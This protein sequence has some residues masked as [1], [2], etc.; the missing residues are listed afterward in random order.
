[1]PTIETGR[2][3]ALIGGAWVA[4]LAVLAIMQWFG[5]GV[6][7]DIWPFG[8][9][10]NTITALHQPDAGSAASLAWQMNDRNPLSPWSIVLV[11]NIILGLDSGFLLLRYAAGL[12][13]ALT[14]YGLVVALSG[15]RAFALVLGI[16]VAVFMANGYPE[17]FYWDYEVALIFALASVA[18]YAEFLNGGRQ[19]YRLYTF[20]VLAGFVGYGIYTI[21]CG[22][23]LAIAYLA[24]TRPTGKWRASSAIRAAV[25]DT[26]PYALLFALFLLIWRAVAHTPEAYQPHPDVGKLIKSLQYGPLHYDLREWVSLLS[27]GWFKPAFLVPGVV[28]GLIAF[29]MAKVSATRDEI[30]T[31]GA[32]LDLLCVAALIALP[33][34]VV[35]SAGSQWLPGI[36]WR[37][38]YQFTTPTIY[39]TIAAAAVVLL[40]KP[41]RSWLWATSVGVMALFATVFS[42]GVNQTGVSITRAERV[43]RNAI[44]SY[45]ADDLR[46]G[47][48]PPFLFVV[49]TD[50]TF[51]WYSTDPLS[52]L[53][54]R[55]W[56]R[57]GNISFRIVRPRDQVAVPVEQLITLEANKVDNAKLWNVPMS[58][59]HLYFLVADGTGVRK[60]PIVQRVTWRAI[61]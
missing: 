50:P 58:Y 42:L 6:G 13:L 15:R 3:R 59:D 36:R 27:K 17:Y 8:E 1:M 35:E 14:S 32:L 28:I 33:T 44:A 46:E 5:L 2:D 56:F 60:L 48:W 39:L 31:L 23:I 9:D 43:L 24:F 37:I 4:F 53:Y 21:E 16:V 10:L 7:F 57:D 34:V 25:L 18:L 41:L 19:N 30:A 52:D 38:I 47:R 40:R 51:F 49:L 45:A 55:T 20:S 54:A 22:S 26:L 61:K 11:R 12:S 29:G